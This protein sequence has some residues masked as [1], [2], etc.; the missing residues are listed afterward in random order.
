MKKI[1]FLGANYFQLS[2]IKHAKEMGYYVITTDY[3]PNNPGHKYADES[4][5]V[6]TTDKDAIYE[7]A[8]KLSVDGIISYA[9]DV[10]ASTAAY[11][12]EK[13][14][15]PT[16][17]YKSV[18]ILTNKNL[19]RNFMKANAF[20]MP[21]GKAFDNLEDAY[22]FYKSLDFTVIVKPIDASG[23]KGVHKIISDDEFN[24][25][26]LDAMSYSRKKQVIVEE[27]I[28]K[29]G[30]QIDGDGFALDG[31]IVFFGVMDQHH[32][33]S[34]NPYA[35][36]GLSIPSIQKE[37]YQEA[38]KKQ[39]QD[40]FSK[41]NIKFGAFNFEYIIGQ[42]NQVY[43]LE[44]GPRNGGNFIPDTVR[45]ASNIDMID[46][47]IRCAVGDECIIPN[48]EFKSYASSFIIHATETGT[49]KGLE[50]ADELKSAIVHHTMF[51]CPGDSI[52]RFRN[53]GDSIGAMVIEFSSQ[54]QMNY[55]IDNMNDY[56]K[57][58][59]E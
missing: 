34:C 36:I 59:V 10:S 35:P 37:E 42:N 31:K 56:I 50:I 13:L 20:P 4:Y 3:L 41:L 57:V 44:I 48:I 55:M 33:L 40:I 47:S 15:L 24:P 2:A 19:F 51:V 58:I 26:F 32:D 25:A 30:Y 17:P 14:N 52:H 1:L 11:V 27:F 16:N 38:A 28:E 12:S 18:E 8:K 7:L 23:S 21:I 29:T 9:S 43:I 45:F 5:N 53:G 6:S 22:A 39:I 49:Y 46:Y 54:E